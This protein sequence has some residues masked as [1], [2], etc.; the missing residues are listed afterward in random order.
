MRNR[1]AFL[2]VV[3]S[4]AAL[5]AT[6]PA[7]TQSPTPEPSGTC[8]AGAY[9]VQAYGPEFV[10]CPDND[11]A[12]C[13]TIQYK[14]TP[15]PAHVATVVSSLNTQPPWTKGVVSVTGGGSNGS[16]SFFPCEGDTVT[17]LGL[18]ACHEEAARINPNG[19]F[20]DFR[21]TVRGKREAAPKSVVTKKGNSIG[22]CEIVGIGEVGTAV[23]NPFET[24]LRTETLRF[25]G[26]AVTFDY[27]LATGD[28][29]NAALNEGESEKPAC[30]V[31]DPPG[32]C[33]DFDIQ[34]VSKLELKLNGTS[35]GSGKFGQGY[36]SS[37]TNSCTTRVI[38][39]RVYTWGS[40]CPE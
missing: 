35:L 20:A 16:F 22:A 34:D 17:N 33:C 23:R 11:P 27:D 3:V 18:W 25:K 29:V 30:G 1:K 13:T 40:P 19:A 5:L 39:G 37:G 32:S 2:S 12:G 26:C 31:G 24:V 38:G 28:V 21:I 4:A 6:T 8:M 9:Q 15:A 7:M 36:V 10:A 14:V